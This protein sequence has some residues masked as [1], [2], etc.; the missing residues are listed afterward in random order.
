MPSDD[1]SMSY[2]RSLGYINRPV[3]SPPAGRT[4]KNIIKGVR[5]ETQTAGERPQVNSSP[6][7]TESATG[8]KVGHARTVRH[9]YF[10]R[11][12][13]LKVWWG[14]SPPGPPYNY[15]GV[16][17]AE[18]DEFTSSPSPGRW[19]NDNPHSYGIAFG[20]PRG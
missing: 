2:W 13:I 4:G 11:A 18:F 15:Y 1:K 14:S 6:Q 5:A 12:Q 20:A 17:Q 16:S 7:S 10:P 3:E 19:L 8:S 9:E